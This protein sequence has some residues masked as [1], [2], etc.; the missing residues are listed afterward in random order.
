M[1]ADTPTPDEVAFAKRWAA[2]QT[3]PVT[4]QSGFTGFWLDKLPPFVNSHNVARG[5][6]GTADTAWSVLARALRPIVASLRP[7]IERDVIERCAKVCG[8]VEDKAE[9]M[10]RMSLDY[11]TGWEE[12]AQLCEFRIRKLSPDATP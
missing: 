6:F 11:T 4:C 10:P 12:S 9:G 3:P 2:M 7:L 8:E 5:E 1:T